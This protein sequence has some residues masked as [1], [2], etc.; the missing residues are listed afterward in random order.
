MPTQP[1]DHLLPP[2]SEPLP[3]DAVLADVV[4]AL[5]DPGL[6]VLQ[7][8][9]GAG[10]TTR[11]PL[12]L[13]AAASLG[14]IVVLEPRRVAARAAARR[15][16]AQL[17]EDLGWTVGLTT[18]DER[19]VSA[20]T[21]LEV[22]TEGVLLRRLQADPALAGTGVVVFD[23]F[24]ERNLEGDL[25]LAF[26]LEA[27]EAL[28][29]DLR[30]VVASATL[31]GP[32]I[33]RLLGRDG[34]PAPVVTAAGRQ[35]PVR[36]EHRE[37]PARGQAPAVTADV[38]VEVLGCR[39][40]DVLVFLPGAAEI[41]RTARELAG[42]ALSDD[43][44]VRPLHGALSAAE[45]DAALAPPGPGE[46]K[47]VL[48]TDLAESS[49]TI[50]GVTTVV[51]AGRSREPRFDAATGMSGLV[52]VP[53]SRASADQR[54]GRAGRTAPGVA[55]RLWPAREHLAR[56]A[57]PRPAIVTDD[58]TGPALEVAA[59]GAE[60]HTLALLDEPPAPAWQRSRAT[61]RD[62]GALDTAGRITPHGRALARLPVHPR[63]GHLLLTARDRDGHDGPGGLGTGRLARLAVEVAA[64][65]A[66]RDVLVPSPDAPTA[67]LAARI[68]VLRGEPPP[69]GTTVRRDALLRA[70]REA[71]RLARLLELPPPA[72]LEAAADPRTT[73]SGPAATAAEPDAFA[74]DPDRA[75]Q[76][77]AL[78]W[79]ERVAVRR[80]GR[81]GA[82]LLAVGRGAELP[83]GDLLAGEDLLAVAHLDRGT[84][85]ARIHLAAT[86][87]AAELRRVLAERLRT[88]EEITW[89]QGDV[90]AELREELGA[91]VLR[92]APVDRP[93]PEAL[94]TALL[95]GLR[96]DGLGLLAWRPEDHQLRGR[97]GFLRRVLG[98][99]WP[100]L[101]DAALL[102]AAGTTLAPFLSGARR[103]ADLAAIRAG[104]VLRS[105]LDPRQLVA[106]DRLAP[107]RC[108]VPSGS[109]LALDYTAG[110]RPVLAVRIQELFGART[111][112]TVLDG[113]VP[114]LLHLLSPSRRPV[115]VT[116]DLAGF[117]ERAYPQVRA[118]LRGRYPRHAWPDDPR[119]AVPLRGTAR[120]RRGR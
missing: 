94:R 116:D 86:V 15:L 76:L 60:V 99:A 75:G 83:E 81:R 65:L 27:R 51:D 26:A 37:A 87:R 119:T 107:A 9:P 69:A 66:D 6:V 47:V 109:R 78:A 46:R 20:R 2:A 97:V 7:A 73:V 95:E 120:R 98:D 17:G 18:R 91:V 90:R 84:T 25:A 61:L 103:R 49:V 50:D 68:R 38:V 79:P 22:V 43:V 63:L 48:A 1:S 71:A 108:T 111:T 89:H 42:R 56:D 74:S 115:Q 44:R 72:A 102:A 10:K 30:L 41:R 118:E 19:R 104:D 80:P 39:D 106:L 62:L 96:S 88:V 8:P 85:A 112:P 3:V 33:A 35:H 55:V 100:E 13:L 54:A 45:Q 31:D 113:Q 82:F 64:L 40:G 105:R 70:R 14:R 34:P 77:V 58:L 93:D 16:A 52:T 59:W 24:H 28:R 110:E 21:R 92:R 57:H 29:P 67:D 5:T 4:A 36:I 101:S 114:V 12:A 23:E 32:R 117:W 53:A 11:V